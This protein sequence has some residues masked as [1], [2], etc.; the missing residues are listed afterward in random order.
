[1]STRAKAATPRKKRAYHH[2]DLRR[3]LIMAAV[4]LISERSRAEFTLRELAGQLGV[5]HAATYHHF[6]D[7]DDLLAAVAEDGFNALREYLERAVETVPDSAL[8]RLRAIASAYVQFAA[9]HPAHFR[10]MYARDYDDAQRFPAAKRAADE[11]AD[12]IN[13]FWS[14][15]YQDGLYREGAR[16]EFSTASWAM[17][18]GLAMLLI[19]GLIH[20]PQGVHIAE[21]STR[22]TR[23]LFVGLA[24]DEGRARV[25]AAMT[26]DQMALL[27]RA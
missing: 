6:K 7:K 14:R 3:G 22:I 23:H 19:N 8:L 12:Y 15:A 16:E 4:E 9:E 26:L 1:M 2:G 24:S 13:T 21:F 11:N 25:E 20:V 18:H 27:E 17:I 10:V 5:T